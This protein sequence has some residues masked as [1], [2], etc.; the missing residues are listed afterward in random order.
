MRALRSEGLFLGRDHPIDVAL[1]VLSLGVTEEHRCAAGLAAET[2]PAALLSDRFTKDVT[3]EGVLVPLAHAIV[4]GLPKSLARERASVSHVNLTALTDGGWLHCTTALM[5]VTEDVGVLIGGALNLSLL[6][7]LGKVVIAL[8][9]ETSGLLV[10]RLIVKS[11]AFNVVAVT[12]LTV[13]IDHVL[14]RVTEHISA[15]L[16]LLQGSC[17]CHP[18]AMHWLSS[19]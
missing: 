15:V 10:V 17:F 9:F 16:A 4:C 5:L 1:H 2:L 12:R 7:L 8:R 3:F 19:C 13:V 11:V 6:G 18:T 14:V